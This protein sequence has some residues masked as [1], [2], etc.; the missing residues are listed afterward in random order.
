MHPSAG[1]LGDSLNMI[2]QKDVIDKQIQDPFI[3]SV[4]WI[5]GIFDEAHAEIMQESEDE[6]VDVRSSGGGVS[7]P[8]ERSE[9]IEVDTEIESTRIDFFQPIISPM[10]FTDNSILVDGEVKMR[11]NRP[12]ISDLDGL[13]S[14]LRSK[15][16]EFS[17]DSIE[18]FINMYF[19]SLA[20]VPHPTPSS[21]RPLLSIGQSRRVP[22]PNWDSFS[23]DQ[24]I[25]SS[26][27]SGGAPSSD[28]PDSDSLVLPRIGFQDS[29]IE[30]V[31]FL[32]SIFNHRC[33]TLS[34]FFTFT[35][36]RRTFPSTS[37]STDHAF[38]SP[39]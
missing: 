30:V 27:Q 24:W 20:L 13:E 18:F 22:S 31:C 11:N 36:A 21:G 33:F 39:W 28:L 16:G 3:R 34:T 6:E 7:I 14:E 5:S 23:I 9:A 38:T 15:L 10:P 35:S 8:S 17:F 2:K 1:A 32:I 26:A 19:V 4:D 25:S 29:N 12:D 37:H